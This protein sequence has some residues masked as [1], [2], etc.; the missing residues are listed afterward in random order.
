MKV[1][2]LT[3]HYTPEKPIGGVNRFSIEIVERLRKHVNVEVVHNGK[4]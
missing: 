2:W 4:P 3:L 1:L